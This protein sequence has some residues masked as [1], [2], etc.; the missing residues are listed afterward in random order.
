MRQ[1]C[2]C[3]QNLGSGGLM[4]IKNDLRVPIG[5]GYAFSEQ[6]VMRQDLPTALLGPGE[7][8]FMHQAGPRDLPRFIIR[9]RETAP[10]QAGKQKIY[11][12]VASLVIRADD[13]IAFAIFIADRPFIPGTTILASEII[14]PDRG[15]MMY[16]RL[17]DLSHYARDTWEGYYTALEAR[18][19][20]E[21]QAEFFR[22]LLERQ[23][24]PEWRN[25]MFLQP[26]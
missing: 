2:W 6:A 5:V 24:P 17:E 13:R 22:R 4:A 21:S 7:V 3:S 1:D 16:S 12:R 20:G 15:Y 14:H 26:R 23:W 19:L 9:H 25:E 18:R 8:G 11:L 10:N